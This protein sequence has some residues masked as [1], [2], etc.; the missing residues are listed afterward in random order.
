MTDTH[1]GRERGPCIGAR[2]RPASAA[3][4]T[5]SEQTSQPGSSRRPGRTTGSEL[6]GTKR[7]HGER[8]EG[9]SRLKY[10]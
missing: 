5:W 8:K 3:S 10:N 6:C 9:A 7:G 2:N 1:L 4:P